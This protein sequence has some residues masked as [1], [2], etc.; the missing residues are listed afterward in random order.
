[1]MKKLFYMSLWLFALNAAVIGQDTLL[2]FNGVSLEG[3]EET[4][5]DGQG[6]VSVK[7]GMISL[8]AGNDLTGITWI[9]DYPVSNYE[10]HL[11][12]M[13]IEG[14]DFFCGLTFPVKGSFCTLVLGGWGGSVLGLS[15]IDGYDAYNNFTGDSRT[16]R[17]GRWYKIKLRVTDDK[18]EAWL[19][20]SDRIV[21]FTIGNYRLSLRWEVEP[22]IPLGI[23]T[24]KTTGA[25]R[26]IQMVLLTEE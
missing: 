25:I 15:S 13:R 9:R 19:D 12:A 21:D 8:G 23:A 24:Y 3:W 20:E 1:M 7:D 10:I 4:Y 2:L 14:N 11:E 16:F 26:N 5:F 17:N 18:I 6:K 22:S